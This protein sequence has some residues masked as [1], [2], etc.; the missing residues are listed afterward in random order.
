MKY[1]LSNILPMNAKLASSWMERVAIFCFCQRE[2]RK[3]EKKK[4]E[5]KQKEIHAQSF[6]NLFYIRVSMYTYSR[7]LSA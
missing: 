3:K 4:R 5:K 2:S 6:V 7:A 1:F